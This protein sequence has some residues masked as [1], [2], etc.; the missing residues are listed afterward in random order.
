MLQW[1]MEG[2]GMTKKKN[3]SVSLT[4]RKTEEVTAKVLKNLKLAL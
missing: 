4:K 1:L 3:Q 2:L